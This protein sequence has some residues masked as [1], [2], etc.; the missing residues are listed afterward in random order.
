[1]SDPAYRSY[2]I[3]AGMRTGSN[4]L[5][6]T[7]N[8]IRR[9]TCFG[10]AF[11]PY[12]MGWPDK[13]ELQGVT[14]AEREADPHLLLRKLLDKP[15][16]LPGFRYFPGHDPRV[17]DAI[18]ADRS[19]AKVVL[20]R[21]PLDSYVSTRLAQETNQWKLNETETPIPASITFDPAGFREMLSETEAFLAGV[22]QRLQASGQSAFW[23]GYDD[24]RDADVMTGLLHWL[25][26]RDLERVEPATDQV[27]QN[28]RPMA[29]KVSNLG[30]MRDALAAMDPF[31]LTRIPGF[32][33]RRGP[34]VPSF[35]TVGAGRGLLFMP[36]R[37]GPTEAVGDWMAGL[38]Q[39]GRDYT[40]SS[41]RGWR[42]DHPGHRAFTVLRHPLLRAWVAFQH[43][44][45]AAKPDLRRTL[46]DVHRVAL[47][48]DEE[49]A[50]MDDAAQARHFTEFLLFLRR[51]LNGQ[52]S[53]PTHPGWASQSEVIAGFSRFGSPDLI[54]REDDLPDEMAMLTHR[55]G[56]SPTPNP[57]APETWPGFL[58][59][60]D[61][62][63]AARNAYARDFAAFGFDR[64][65]RI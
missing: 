17:L 34:A 4:L 49:L 45:A 11:N 19:C 9:V 30:A 21:N 24:L 25:G 60:P 44:L 41:L 29:E 20:T 7:L 57:P 39:L 38:G 10:E 63:N 62:A 58:A 1:M 6:A 53:L 12:M 59:D 14:R 40:Q 65:P 22:M 35:L 52:S 48:P 36:V 23:L 42:R 54:A 32:E 18:L 50:L 27:P 61:L 31:G 33:P 8:R 46:R 37:G 26:R 51:N 16:H 3:F 15:N 64:L 47:P 5:E 28:P 13:D 43:V 55:T 2:V 56:I